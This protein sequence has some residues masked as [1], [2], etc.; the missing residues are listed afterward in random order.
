MAKGHPAIHTTGRLRPAVAIGK[1]GLHLAVIIY[2]FLNRPVSRYLPLYLQKPF[3]ITHF[4]PRG[5]SIA[6]RLKAYKGGKQVNHDFIPDFPAQATTE[7]DIL[8][9]FSVF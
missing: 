5:A 2:P 8:P 6:Q 7:L 9:V 3:W 1:T 4:I